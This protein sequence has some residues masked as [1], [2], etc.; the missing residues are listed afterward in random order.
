[1]SQPDGP[2]SRIPPKPK[3]P[4]VR[5]PLRLSAWLLVIAVVLAGVLGLSLLFPGQLTTGG[6]WAAVAQGVLLIAFVSLSLLTRGLR[7]SRVI[8]DLAIWA[9]I[10]L[11]ALLI[12]S[13]RHEIGAA[14]HLSPAR[15]PASAPASPAPPQPKHAAGLIAS[16]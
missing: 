15:P 3:T 9:V 5:P 14:L 8:R 4:G 12:Y 11:L 13:L 16:L 1:M 7:L 10:I 2:W 6:D